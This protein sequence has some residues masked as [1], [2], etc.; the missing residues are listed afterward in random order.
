MNLMRQAHEHELPIVG[1]CLGGQI[2]TRA[3]GGTVG[4]CADGIQL[5]W[6]DVRLSPYG[7]E[8]PLHA[9]IAWTNPQFHWNREQI[10]TAPPG[11]RVLASSDRCAIESWTLGVRTYAFQH[12]PEI[13]RDTIETWIADEP[14]ALEEAMMTRETLDAQTA[15]HFPTFERLTDR[16]F[17]AI[18]L[19]L[20]PVDRRYRGIA[21]ELHH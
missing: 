19:L 14:Y 21:K 5:G 4:P 20:M 1:L 15:T 12:H 8:D 11:A 6:F 7:R 17:H 9:G 16:L 10:T 13:R 2:V 18:A 3:L